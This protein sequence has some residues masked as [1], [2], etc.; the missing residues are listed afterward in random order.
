[1]IEDELIT[2][3]TER[4]RNARIKDIRVGLGYICTMLESGECG[5]A[6]SFRNELG[7]CCSVLAQAGDLIGK[8]CEEIIPWLKEKNILKAAVGLSTVNAVL[9]NLGQNS[10]EGNVIEAIKLSREEKFGMIGDFGPVLPFVRKQTDNIFVFER[11]PEEKDG[12]YPQKSIPDHLPHCDVVLITATSII[13][14]TI[15]EVL[16]F[17]PKAREV[18]IVGPSTPLYPDLFKRHNITLLAGTVVTD[19]EKMLRIISQG[20]GTM[21]M[22]PAS[23]HVLVSVAR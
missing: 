14:H 20:G 1:M 11:I 6:Y 13:N 17:C 2:Y 15:D 16:S 23:R 4:S 7:H 8:K 19:P 12:I 3:A 21:Q 18:F 22:K 9:N 5:L 10:A